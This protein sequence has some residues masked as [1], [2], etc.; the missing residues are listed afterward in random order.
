MFNR[1]GFLALAVAA[2]AVSSVY[3]E[4]TTEETSTQTEVSQESTEA[5][6]E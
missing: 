1:F 6:A 3:S 5:A 2:F 4:E